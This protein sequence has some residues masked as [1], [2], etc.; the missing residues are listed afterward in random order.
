MPPQQEDPRVTPP[1]EPTQEGQIV[2]PTAP[3]Y[4]TP[5]EVQPVAPTPSGQTLQ[6]TPTPSPVSSEPANLPV[7]PITTEVT[8]QTSVTSPVSPEV[9]SQPTSPAPEV[10]PEPSV[11]PTELRAP[12]QTIISP[13]SS[14]PTQP[15]PPQPV[16]FNS[17]NSKAAKKGRGLVTKLVILLLLAGGGYFA[18]TFYS[19]TQ[20]PKYSA[21]DLTQFNSASY[22]YK[23]PKQWKS[24]QGSQLMDKIIAGTDT[25]FSEASVFAYKLSKDGQNAQAGVISEAAAFPASDTQLQ[26][27]LQ[28]PDTKKQ[29][30]DELNTNSFDS[31]NP[32]CQ[33]ITDKTVNI[34]YSSSKFVIEYTIDATC[35]YTAAKAKELGV[36]SAH[37]S[38]FIGI[39]N[40]KFYV[41]AV[42][43]NSNI[44]QKN[45]AFFKSQLI[46]SLQPK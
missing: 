44:W 9:A 42:V 2:D 8:E 39:K 23:Y 4:N 5:P 36:K 20:A 37:S 38:A 33:S 28:Q 19:K 17:A 26:A 3:V 12:T 21:K 10:S 14:P 7:S 15:I 43:S 31:S 16:S 6:P 22:S 40:S 13:D 29:F 25:K 46:G 35:Q 11:Q 27:I 30:E 32:D 34:N 45:Q 41:L 18:W 1:A 24:A